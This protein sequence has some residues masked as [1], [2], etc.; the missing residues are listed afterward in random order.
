MPSFVIAIDGPAAS[1]KGT[2]AKKI[3]SALNFAHMDTGMLYRAVAH[4]VLQNHGDP[5]DETTAVQAT[6]NIEKS[7]NVNILTDEQLRSD[8]LGSAASKI[9]SF[10]SVRAVLLQIQRD[11]AATPPHASGAVLDG[12]D[13]GTVVCPEAPV[14]LFITASTEVR[15]GRRFK[16]LQS[17][18]IEATYEAVLKDMEERDRRDMERTTAPLKPAP[19]AIIIDTSAMDEKDVLERALSVIASKR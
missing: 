4:A 19:D 7:F 2:L 12:R 16:E 14:K 3:A 9:S 8:A 13:I 10:A 5:D 11:Y 6:K 1:G 17:R 15:A 18:G